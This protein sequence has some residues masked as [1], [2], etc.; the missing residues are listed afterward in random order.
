MRCLASS[1]TI[2][3]NGTGS[4]A[5]GMTATAV[6]SVSTESS[7]ILVVINQSSRSHAPIEPPS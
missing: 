1:V 7:C 5:S 6:C 3:T 4:A 2:I